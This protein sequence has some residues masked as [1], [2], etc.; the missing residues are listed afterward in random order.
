MLKSWSFS[1]LADFEECK[2][3]AYL[4]YVAKV[5]EPE[6]PL[7]PGKKEHANDRGTRIH[8]LAEDFVNGKLKNESPP[9]EL[10]KFDAEFRHMRGLFSAGKVSLEG[11]WGYAHDWA[12]SDWFAAWCRIKLDAIVFTEPTKAVVIDYKTGR[13]FGN[14]FKHNQQLQ[15]YTA[16]SFLRFPQLEEIDTELWYLDQDEIASM[17][18][19]RPQGLRFK[20]GFE[21]RGVTATTCT[22]FPASPNVHVCKWCPY[23]ETGDCK[24]SVKLNPTFKGI[25]INR[26]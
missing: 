11:E 4:K 26:K 5:P 12:P 3:R 18:F 20:T 17:H 22:E 13:R 19:T 1:R 23:S 10:S 9:P 16:G 7:P 6:R 25:S 15:L 14:E 24:S 21:R 2:H 8:Q